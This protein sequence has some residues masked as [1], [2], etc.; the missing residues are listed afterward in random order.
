LGKELAA[1]AGEYKLTF[2]QE[3][4]KVPYSEADKML[5]ITGWGL[6]TEGKLKPDVTLPGG[7]IYSAIPNGSYDMDGGT[8]MATPHAAGA[9]ALIKQALEERFPQYSPEQIHTLLR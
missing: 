3:V 5:Y 7:M 4:K 2:H 9:T 1:H 6:S 8:S